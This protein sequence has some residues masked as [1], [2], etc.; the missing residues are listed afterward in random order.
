MYSYFYLTKIILKDSLS[1]YIF[2]ISYKNNWKELEL[3]ITITKISD[4]NKEITGKW[5]FTFQILDNDG[6]VFTGARIQ[7]RMTV[8][9]KQMPIVSTQDPSN[10]SAAAMSALGGS[11]LETNLIL[12]CII[13]LYNYWPFIHY[14]SYEILERV[15]FFMIIFVLFLIK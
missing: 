9:N 11:N 15:P 6:M 2:A 5:F 14:L 10:A 7:D 8:I 13:L 3:D 12:S 1:A 4:K